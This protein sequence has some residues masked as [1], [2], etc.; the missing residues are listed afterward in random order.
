[1]QASGLW[2]LREQAQGPR[3]N[4]STMAF[5]GQLASTPSQAQA[6]LWSSPQLAQCLVRQGLSI[7]NWVTATPTFTI[8]PPSEI[9]C[10][11][12]LRISSCN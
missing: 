8:A 6:A 5:L 3:H 2:P 10:Q 7:S 9:A 4:Y 11:L 12:Q 1:M